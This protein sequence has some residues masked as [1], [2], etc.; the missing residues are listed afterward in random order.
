LSVSSSV[1]SLTRAHSR[2]VALP[3]L[4]KAK[5]ISARTT[6]FDPTENPPAKITGTQTVYLASAREGAWRLASATTPATSPSTR[7]C[8]LTIR[9]PSSDQVLILHV[10]HVSNHPTLIAIDLHLFALASAQNNNNESCPGT[11]NSTSG[12]L[13]RLTPSLASQCLAMSRLLRPGRR[14]G[15]SLHSRRGTA[16]TT[17]T[18]CSSIVRLSTIVVSM[19]CECPS[20]RAHARE[21]KKSNLMHKYTHTRMHA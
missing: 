18:R 17:A 4:L 21:K 20:M 5:Q 10:P 9:G 3:I 6:S 1:C 15:Q 2:L 11:R 16:A 19:S 13:S 14:T 7:S 12:G 8:R